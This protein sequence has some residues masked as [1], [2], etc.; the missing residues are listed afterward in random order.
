MTRRRHG[1]DAFAAQQAAGGALEHLG[2][3]FAGAGPLVAIVAPLRTVSESNARGHWSKRAKRAK[4]QRGLVALLLRAKGTSPRPLTA[5]SLDTEGRR[6][7]SRVVTLTRIAPREL[8]DD[9]LRGAMKACRDGVADW[10]GVD[11]RD[12]RVE[13]RYEQTKGSSYA[14]RVIVRGE[15]E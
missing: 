3:R 7:P 5:Y 11:D 1:L 2:P 14:V 6:V 8:D 4:E 15:L 12:P 10:L 13:W 9:N